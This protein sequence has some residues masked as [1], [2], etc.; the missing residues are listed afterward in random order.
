MT[1]ADEKRLKERY[2]G[3]MGGLSEEAYA[4]APDVLWLIEQVKKYQNLHAKMTVYAEQVEHSVTAARRQQLEASRLMTTAAI[5]RDAALKER[6]ALREKQAVWI[7]SPEAAA[8]LQGYRAPVKVSEEK[9]VNVEESTKHQALR[10]RCEKLEAEVE[11]LRMQLAGCSTAAMQ[12]TEASKADRIG[13]ENPYYSAAYLDICRAVDR[14]MVMRYERDR[15]VADL[16]TILGE[17][18]AGRSQ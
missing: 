17:I 14:E 13:P 8:R 18:H 6:D 3:G 12:N 9:P 4:C 2:E 11:V 7:A 1:E 5:E 10:E 15:A 16:E